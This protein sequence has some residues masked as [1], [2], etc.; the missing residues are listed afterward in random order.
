MLGLGRMKRRELL[1]SLNRVAADRRRCE[2]PAATEVLTKMLTSGARTHRIY[3]TSFAALLLLSLIFAVVAAGAV[4]EDT[5]VGPP[6]T[7]AP[8]QAPPLPK[9]SPLS[10]PRSSSQVGFP[11]VLTGYVIS[12]ST[13]GPARVALGQKL[14]F[15]AR[16]SGDGTVACATCH[17]PARAFTDGRPV[18]VGIH[19]RIGQRNAPTVLNALYNKAQF[20]DGRVSTLEQQAALPITNPFE[21]GSATIDDAVSRIA[22]DKDYQTQFM[23]AFG[24]A[25][26]EQDMLSA[27]AAYERTLASFDSSFDHF[28]AGDVSAIS[29]SSRR[30]WELFNGKARCHLCHALTD[31]QRD[32]TLLMDNDFHNIGIGILRH[33][34]A[35]LAQRA[36][37]ELAQG[38]LPAIDTVAITSEMSVLGRFLVTRMQS[39]IASF[40]TPGLRNVLV[41]GPYFHDGSM[42]TLWDV[43]DHYNKGDGVTNPWLD[44]DMQPL[45]LTEPEIDDVVAFL[46]SLTSPQ[47]KAIGDQEYARQLALSKVSRPQRDTTRAFGPK[48]KQP[49]PSPF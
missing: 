37:R 36:E 46:A 45:A 42:Q 35:P 1:D 41:T 20:W 30:G 25:V 22:A 4:D 16:L 21:M 5:G 40:K 26:N 15:E 24:R 43:M 8:G 3:A 44:K 11:T 18:S 31:N 39:D 28:I 27:I 2:V 19:G 17:D 6:P 34:V 29:D 7:L 38:H 13:L 47:Y 9:P 10:E 14:F 33:H 49:E 48:P 23:Q 12:P 32:I